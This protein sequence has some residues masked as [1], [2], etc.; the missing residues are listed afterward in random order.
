MPT[1]TYKFND[2]TKCDIEASD[3]IFAVITEIEQNERRLYWRDAKYKFLVD[4]FEVFLE[5]GG[6]DIE[7]IGSD[8]HDILIRREDAVRLHKAMLY[9][10][11]KQRQLVKGV[12]FDDMSLRQ[13]AQ[14]TG[15]SHQALS[16]QMM[17]IFKKLK[18]LL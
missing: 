4:H 9:L 11:E 1:I 12:F 10:S 8:P 2:G 16:Q 17:T 3:E 14:L 7:D 18:K 6:I 5:K 13:I 15:I